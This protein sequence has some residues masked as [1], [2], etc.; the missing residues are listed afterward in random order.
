MTSQ[1]IY[2][3]TTDIIPGHPNKMPTKCELTWASAG[4]TMMSAY[5]GLEKWTQ[6]HGYDAV[7]GVRFIMCAK[8]DGEI[9][10]SVYGTAVSWE[11]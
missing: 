7:V 9:V 8:P 2:M 10:Y 6:E 11:Y 3:S 1:D 5:K 4:A